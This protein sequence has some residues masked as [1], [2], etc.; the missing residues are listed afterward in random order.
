MFTKSEQV[1]KVVLTQQKCVSASVLTEITEFIQTL[2]HGSL[3]CV[4]EAFGTGAADTS[5]VLM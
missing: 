2:L 1:W 3:S 5:E 4:V